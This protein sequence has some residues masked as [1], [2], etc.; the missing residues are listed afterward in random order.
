MLPLYEQ[1]TDV[2][3]FSNALNSGVDTL[4]YLTTL[5]HFETVTAARETTLQA[6]MQRGNYHGNILKYCMI[7]RPLK[8]RVPGFRRIPIFA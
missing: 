6:G 3:T 7:S 1:D 8:Y 4:C 5:T 2:D